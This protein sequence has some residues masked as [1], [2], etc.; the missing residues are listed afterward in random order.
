[1]S[2]EKTLIR[3]RIWN[4]Y[5]CKCSYCGNPVELKKMQIDHIEPIYRGY[6]DD[7]LERVN[8]ERGK[9]EESNYNPSCRRCNRWKGTFSLEQFRKEI[10]LQT[11]RLKRDSSAFRMAFDYNRIIIKHQP[12]IFWFEQCKIIDK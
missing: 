1:M 7:E 11:E 8:I 12:V 6:S 9:D 3:K 10:E 4:K 2:K 5:G